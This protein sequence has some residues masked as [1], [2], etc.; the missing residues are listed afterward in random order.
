[1]RGFL[2]EEDKDVYIKE[3]QRLRFDDFHP[4]ELGGP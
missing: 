3:E 4:E 1:V 2:A